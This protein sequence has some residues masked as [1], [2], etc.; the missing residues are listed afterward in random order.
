MVGRAADGSRQQMS[1][2]F[3]ENLVLWYTDRVQEALGFEVF[4]HLRRGE[5]G[6]APEI[7]SYLPPLVTNDNRLQHALPVIGAVNVAGTQGTPLKV[8][9]LVEQE[10]GVITGAA[11]VAIIGRSLLVAVG[12][13]DAAVHVEDDL[14]RRA[15][16]MHT[17][18][19]LPGKIGKRGEVF[20]GGQNL[21]LEAPH[22]TGRGSLFRDSMAADNPPHDRVEAEPVGIVH[23]VVPAEAS[24]N[25]LAEL[26]DKTVATVLPT[27]GVRE[28]VPGNLGQSDRIVQFPVRQQASVGSDLGTVELKLEPTVKIQPQNPR[29]R[30]THRVSHINAPNPPIT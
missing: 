16:V 17:V 11:E 25:G 3:L 28:C 27:T 19:P 21:R 23:V 30:F 2:A 24:E 6:V 12:R 7:Q 1:D 9:E 14:R 22:L 15:T 26:P 18:D 13:A 29:I 20:L 4:V 8:A 10:Q 5:G